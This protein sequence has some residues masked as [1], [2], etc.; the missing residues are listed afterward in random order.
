MKSM[1]ASLSCRIIFRTPPV[2]FFAVAQR[3]NGPHPRISGEKSVEMQ[4]MPI[5]PRNLIDNRPRGF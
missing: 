5:F 2:A 3:E 4:E 1:L